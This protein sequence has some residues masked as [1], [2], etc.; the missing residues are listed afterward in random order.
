MQDTLK[1]AKAPRAK[2]LG[3]GAF[4]TAY[5]LPTGEVFL[6]STCWTKEALALFP[7]R[8]ELFPKITQVGLGEYFME[9][10]PKTASLKTSL[11]GAEY[12]F[13]R[14]LREIHALHIRGMGRQFW[15]GIFTQYSLSH[16]QF[17]LYF[18]QLCEAVESLANYDEKEICF[19]ISPRNVRAV[20]GRLLLLDVFYFKKQ[21]ITLKNK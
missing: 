13:Y 17:L 3:V 9:Y 6:R 2:T 1:S 16:P 12:A 8:G 5:L 7:V 11:L 14:L 4:T 19:E 18:L 15:T 20:R 21:L 10:H